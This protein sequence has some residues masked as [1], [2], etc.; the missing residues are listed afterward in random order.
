MENTPLPNATP[1]ASTYQ[2]TDAFLSSCE[3]S[4]INA[5]DAA[6]APLL[7][8]RGYTP[9]I[10]AAKL[11]ELATLKTLVASQKKEY[12]EQFAATEEYTKAVDLLHPEYM[13]HLALAR[14]AFK[15]DTAAKTGL[16]L[17]GKRAQSESGYTSQALL[18][19]NGVLGNPA[20]KTKLAAF[21]I[22]DTQLQTGKTGYT[23][24]ATKSANKTKESGEAQAATQAR[25]KALDT[26]STWFSDFKVVATIALNKTPQLK[27][28]LGWKE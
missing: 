13:D 15:T 19:Y 4:L 9:A 18:F 1:K 17:K 16:D 21:G 5:S 28:K 23:A 3:T 26:F 2:N 14:V 24:L 27:E 7:T 10:I 12:G 25:D 22:T 8:A 11:T 20:Y 6:I